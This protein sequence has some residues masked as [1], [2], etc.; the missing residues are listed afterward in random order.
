[1][2][3]DGLSAVSVRLASDRPARARVRA[4]MYRGQ[5]E[6]A[7]EMNLMYRRAESFDLARG[8]QWR[9]MSLPRED[10]SHDQWYTV[11][12]LLE[13]ALPLGGGEGAAEARPTVTIVASHDNPPRGGALWI[14]GERHHGRSLFLR[15]H[16][17]GRTVYERFTTEAEPHLPDWLKVP[18]LQLLV[19]GVFH[20]ALLAFAYALM[21]ES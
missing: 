10:R 2:L 1:M 17:P 13:D 5:P 18:A 11:E 7:A 14:G 9:T 3:G 6:D 15:A 20:W 19:A 12:L 4:T 16:R 21:T 8:Q